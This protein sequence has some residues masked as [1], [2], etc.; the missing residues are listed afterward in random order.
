MIH[1][2]HHP[3]AAP[4]ATVRLD[5]ALNIALSWPEP[6]GVDALKGA[7]LLRDG[8]PVKAPE[9]AIARAILRTNPR[10]LQAAALFF[11]GATTR[12]ARANSLPPEFLAATLLQESAYDPQA[13]SSAG[14]IGIAQFMPDTAAGAGLDPTDPFAS[15]GAAARLIGNYVAAYRDRYDEPYAT[16]L[17]AYNAGPGAVEQYDGVPPYAETRE[18]IDLIYDRWSRIASYEVSQDDTG[19]VRKKGVK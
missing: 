9:L 7:V 4:R 18:Y 1:S 13:V 15:I 12:A 8:P 16:A 14:A 17:A 11:A 3:N 5:R 10:L 6:S 2:I 19:A